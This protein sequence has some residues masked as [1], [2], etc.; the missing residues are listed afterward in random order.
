M[1]GL[2][3]HLP[4][5]YLIFSFV[6]SFP[7]L[8]PQA[9][10]S[11]YTIYTRITEIVLPPELIYKENYPN[12][13]FF[14]FDYSLEI[15][16]PSGRMLYIFSHSTCLVFVDGNLSF[17]NEQYIGQVVGPYYC[18]AAFTNHTINPGITKGTLTF[19]L[20]VNDTL[21]DPPNGNYTVWNFLDDSEEQHN[22]HHFTSE[23]A[24]NGSDIQITH[25]GAN[26]TFLFP[27]E[28]TP[29]TDL[30]YSFLVTLSVG[31][32]VIFLIRKRY[33]I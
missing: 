19:T 27:E 14:E 32:L 1:K 24:V 17:E 4:S 7:L 30:S 26:A 9:T 12:W 13:T 16:N 28:P 3:K 25:N 23:I 21:E 2:F 6:L 31:L 18:G 22:Y 33:N 5:I 15:I 29:T 20:E 11:E 10:V 8:L